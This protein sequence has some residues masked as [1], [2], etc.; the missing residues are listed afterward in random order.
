[1]TDPNHTTIRREL[2]Q[3]EEQ[4]QIASRTGDR[5]QIRALSKRHTELSDLV[6]RFDALDRLRREL[7]ET[8]L[9]AADASDPE[10]QR[11]AAAELSDL[12]ER[13]QR[14]AAD[15]DTLVRPADPNDQKD[16]FVEIRAGAGGDE[17]GLFAAELFRMYARYAENRGWK[18]SLISS[19]PTGV[20]GLKEVIFEVSGQSVY[21]TL[22]HESGVHR[23]QRIPATEKSGRVHTST[24]TV[25]VI[26]EAAETDLTI[27][28]K[29]IKVET[30]TARGHGG[31]SVNTTYSAVRITH[32]STGLTVSMQDERSQTQN[33]LRAMQVLRSRLLA[34]RAAERQAE[35]SSL[36]KSQIGSGDRS[37]KIR[38]YNLPQD[39]VTDHRI[40]LTLHGVQNILDG[41]LEPL[42]EALQSADR[43]PQP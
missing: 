6:A 20:G 17:A 9:A 35:E 10:L 18:T 13:E 26:P 34:K 33:R 38:T 40:K 37:E 42:I 29:D 24:A 8:R 21:R 3:V 15:V 11:L 43:A 41:R 27:D 7:T 2:S 5:E 14:M 31:Q 19:N 22:K 32:L 39:R 23:V 1:M 25:A 36:R 12:T 28:P 30:S 16:I 4:L